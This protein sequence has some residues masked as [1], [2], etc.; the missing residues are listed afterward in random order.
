MGM[1]R[2]NYQVFHPLVCHTFPVETIV[3]Q[4]EVTLANLFDCDEHRAIRVK[5]LDCTFI[6]FVETESWED[7]SSAVLLLNELNEIGN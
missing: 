6:S 3:G 1:T 4:T 5:I 7:K 2:P